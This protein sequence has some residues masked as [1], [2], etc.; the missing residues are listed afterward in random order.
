MAFGT[1][2]GGCSAPGRRT[3]VGGLW[4]LALFVVQL[5]LG[6][7]A[8]LA[9]TSSS[10]PPLPEMVAPDA[11]GVDLLNGRRVATDSAVSIGASDKP[12]MQITDG[13]DG[14][15]GTPVAGFHYVDGFYPN[16]TD[17]F[18]LGARAESN[19]FGDGTKRTLPDGMVL[20]GNT[21]IEGEGSRWNFVATGATNQ[22]NPNLY[23][24]T[25]VRPDGEI[26]TY[27][28]SSIPSAGDIRGKLRS[29]TSSAGYQ[30]NFEWTPVSI[31]YNLTKVTLTNRR[32]AYCDPQ[33]GSCTGSY[34]WPTLVWTFDGSG[35]STVTTSGLRS[36]V[37][38]PR[39][40]GAQVGGTQSNPTWEWNALFTSGAGV[41][42]T[43]TGRYN[44][45]S[46][47]PLQLYYGRQ[48]SGTAP[49]IDSSAI[50]RVQ[51]AAG[52]TSYNYT[53]SCPYGF[54]TTTRT[55]PLG[56]SATRNGSSFGDEL[57]RTTSY[58]YIDQFG[59]TATVGG[60]I[61]KTTSVTYP[62]GNKVVWDYGAMYG[63]QNLASATIVPKPGS[64]ETSV[65]WSWGY[66]AG[67]TVAT[68]IYCNKP[69]YEIDA[70]GNRT[71]YTYD[72]VHGGVLT[73][74]LPADAN[75]I[76]PQYR[77]TYQQLSAKV[78]NASGQLVSESPI[79][80]LVS[81]STC[82]TQ[83]SCAGTADEVVTS[84]T[85][86]DNL[87][88][89]SETVRAGDWSVSATTTKTYDVVGNV[90]SVDGPLPGAADTTRYVYDA[91]RRLVATMG[92]DPDGA[93]PL[94]VA[95]TRTT[96]NGDSQPTQV[97]TGHATDQSDA[98]LAAMTVDRSVVTAYDS[99][100]R[101]AS[102]SVVAAGQTLAVTQYGYDADGRLQCIAIRMNPAAFG[103]LPASACSLGAQGSYGPDRITRNV[104]DDAGQ[105]V[106]VQKAY[107][108]S[109]QQNYAAYG[110]SP[111]GKRTSVTDANGNVASLTFD[112]LDR[113]VRWT[114]PS[115]TTPGWVNA[116]DYE[117]YGYDQNANRTSLR[118]RDGTTLT[119]TYDALNRV[120]QKTV[121][122]SVGG[123]A[124]YGVFYGYELGGQPTFARFGST[125]GPGATS[126]YDS[127]GRL[128]TATSNMDGV[129]RSMNS[130]YD[131]AG[132]RTLLTGDA[133]Y[134]A[135]FTYDAASRMT[136]Y[137]GVVSIGYDAAG[138]R[139]SLG[140]GPGYTTS[141]ASFGYDGMSRLT[142]LTHDL[143]GTSADQSLGFVY[144]PAS[145]IVTRTASNDSYA[146]NTA[147]NVSR[148]Y[149]VNGLNQYTVAG[150]A[151]FAYDANGNLTSDGSTNF[152]Y[153]AEN[154]LVSASGARSA[155]LSYDPLGRLWQV[156][157]ASGTTRFLY[158]R[159]AIVMEYDG[160]GN[161]LRSYVHGPTADEPFTWYEAG[162]R[163]HFHADHQG[164]I[165]SVAD[166]AGNL[167]AI[168]GY[169]AWGVPNAGNVG[170]FG[171]TGQTWLPEL[172]LW[173]YK[174]RI[175]SPTLGRFLQTDPVGYKDQVNLY[176]YVRNDPVNRLDTQGTWDAAVHNRVFEAAVGNRF[177]GLQMDTIE[178]YSQHQDYGGPNAGYNPAH[179]LRDPGETAAHATAR[180]H[181]YVNSEIAAGREA[182]RNNNEAQAEQH[183]A[184]AGHAVQDFYSPMHR[185][186]DGSPR[187]YRD[188][189]GR[190]AFTNA[191]NQG[192][193]PWEGWGHE[194]LKDVSPAVMAKMIQQTQEVYRRIF[195]SDTHAILTHRC[196]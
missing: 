109:L 44:N 63:P 134:Y 60:P 47:F 149:S 154:R 83:A 3:I 85:Y 13:T 157:S 50:W 55:D 62:E 14:L 40:Q 17:F 184:R 123:A 114:F 71:D 175:Y 88:P 112:G 102:E 52:T 94:P 5:G 165:V 29:I 144:S 69:S 169:D 128:V 183:F 72:P 181:A 68:L 193:S 125:G 86:D 11:A 137:L 171:Y 93:G 170:R 101:E 132:N 18:V 190:T 182:L 16:F 26:L 2:G 66:P 196:S 23:M 167:V 119:Y 141:S 96:Y 56:K 7:N 31:T 33:T 146:S 116:A 9:Q 54:A 59:Q 6:S 32:Y 115:P 61:H 77:Y 178:R 82:R 84:Y 97:D 42:R 127:L 195:C 51:E 185:D 64:A 28:Y 19:R 160:G 37:Y 106:T 99:S 108:T 174:A 1:I 34:A 151:T 194:Q 30:V 8:A 65:A 74:T 124:G 177:N 122:A 87:L 104:Y 163:R 75:G 166:D 173:Y 139:S 140:M 143:A 10:G 148:A 126:G 57:G 186:P 80:K 189:A 24:T 90:V 187:V 192:H 164:S 46:F 43:Y 103:S 176:A 91:L 133:G 27:N 161:L 15:G 150:P 145:Q 172:G 158:D 22:Q 98:A 147:Y 100:G 67:C 188:D 180:F 131:A 136:A 12:A 89:V 156:S 130:Q 25:L 70:R 38:G 179:Y 118:K 45:T 78:L 48:I 152:V 117:Q 110:Y 79:W 191:V 20:Q 35:G 155:T 95:V 159:D 111:N 39:T 168:N 73:K 4:L 58:Q 120:T 162:I 36:V 49:C 53:N 21:L 135:P 121:P 107:G 81:T 92:P 142:A 76:R 138:R 113:Q 41:T 153:D 129:S 105:L